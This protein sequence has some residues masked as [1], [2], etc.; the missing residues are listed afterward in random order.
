MTP[1]E[2]RRSLL[3]MQK[4]EEPRSIRFSKEMAARIEKHRAKLR[5]KNPGVDVSFNDAMR[6]LIERGLAAENGR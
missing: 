5:A 4:L 1:R 3:N 2:L 6:A